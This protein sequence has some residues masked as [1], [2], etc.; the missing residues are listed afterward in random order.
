METISFA[1]GVGSVLGVLLGTLVVWLTL[2][3]K[4]LKKEKNDLNVQINHLYQ[5]LDSRITEVYRD[6]D[7]LNNN[8]F[9]RL[10]NDVKDINHEIKQTKSYIDSR[11]DKL[12]D[13]YFEYNPQLNKQ[14]KKQVLND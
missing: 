1:L 3:V 5:S 13:T 12:I 11:I 9:N 2:Q 8:I 6:I 7:G 14:S 10:E 4:K